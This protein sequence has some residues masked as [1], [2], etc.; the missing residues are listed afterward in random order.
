MSPSLVSPDY[1][2]APRRVEEETRLTTDRHVLMGGGG[3]Y[4]PLTM[5]SQVLATGKATFCSARWPERINNKE[6][7]TGDQ[8]LSSLGDRPNKG[9][10]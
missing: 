4:A 10:D 7:K 9:A 6:G 5:T 1:R 2:E 8:V 3:A